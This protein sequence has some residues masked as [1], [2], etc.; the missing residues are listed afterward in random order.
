M[1]FDV[2]VHLQVFDEEEEW[3][4]D[5]VEHFVERQLTW[6]DYFLVTFVEAQEMCEEK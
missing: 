2:V 6:Q 1:K 3:D 5:A 4:A